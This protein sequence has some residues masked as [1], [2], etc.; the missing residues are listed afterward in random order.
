MIEKIC[1][2]IGNTE[3]FKWYTGSFLGQN[4]MLIAFITIIIFIFTDIKF[5]K[6]DSYILKLWEF[7]KV[8]DQ[9]SKFIY[10]KRDSD[11]LARLKTVSMKTNDKTITQKIK[12]FK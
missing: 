3:I 1:I 4:W 2:Y 5:N 10:E 7:I 9:K 6:P 8:L 11:N 12:L